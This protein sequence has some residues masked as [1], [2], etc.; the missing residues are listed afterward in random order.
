MQRRII[1]ARTERSASENN[2]LIE[3]AQMQG[4]D[5]LFSEFFKG[6]N[7]SKM[8]FSVSFISVLGM[9]EFQVILIGGCLK[10][11]ADY[12]AFSLVGVTS[13]FVKSTENFAPYFFGQIAGVLIA[14]LSNDLLFNNCQFL[15]VT[16]WNLITILWHLWD[17][18]Y[19]SG[20][21][22][23]D[24][25]PLAIFGLASGFSDMYIMILLPMTLADKNRQYAYELTM[26]GTIIAL[27]NLTMFVTTSLFASFV[28]SV[29][30]EEVHL[31]N[32]FNRCLIILFLLLSSWAFWKPAWAQLSELR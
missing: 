10:H 19:P 3:L 5:D 13:S 1:L 17:I 6:E 32:I 2:K 12:F 20:N 24:V 22:E 7:R 11:M 27:V 18:V 23:Y 9:P 28:I 15:L 25:W 21:L 4:R 16:V 8:G 30:E 29:I 26:L 31:G 14:G